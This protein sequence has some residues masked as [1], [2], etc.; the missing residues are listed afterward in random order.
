MII[1]L[2]FIII[3]EDQR[4][5]FALQNFPWARERISAEG[6]DS[7]GKRPSRGSPALR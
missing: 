6:K 2:Q 7:L 1:M 5:H 4:T 3:M